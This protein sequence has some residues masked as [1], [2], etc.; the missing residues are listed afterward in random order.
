VGTIRRQGLST[1]VDT[2]VCGG[3]PRVR[4][5]LIAEGVGGADLDARTPAAGT[6][7]FVAGPPS[8]GELGRAHEDLAD[9]YVTHGREVTLRQQR[10]GRG[11]R[12]AGHLLSPRVDPP[13]PQGLL[14]A[15]G[16]RRAR[17]LSLKVRGLRARWLGHARRG[18]SEDREEQCRD[19]AR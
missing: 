7:F 11:N 2:D 17:G 13:H 5:P 9:L 12:W 18:T 6:G 19:R 8:P 14:R 16:S 4:A 10:G 3:A 1:V 15:A